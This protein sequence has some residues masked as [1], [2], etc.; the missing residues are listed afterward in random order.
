M[1]K[2][3]ASS[4]AVAGAALA[5]YATA[6]AATPCPTDANATSSTTQSPKKGQTYV[7][8]CYNHKDVCLPQRAANP[9]QKQED[10]VAGVCTKPG[11][12]SKSC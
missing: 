6:F 12:A 11:T 4:L 9:H 8:V 10:K 2:L 1:E 3:V 5:F 7:L